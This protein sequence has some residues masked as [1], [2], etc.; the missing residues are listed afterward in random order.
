[1]NISYVYHVINQ[2]HC[3]RFQYNL[4]TMEFVK[5]FH[6]ALACQAQALER[7]L[8]NTFP[9][10]QLVGW[11]L[12]YAVTRIK[13]NQLNYSLCWYSVTRDKKTLQCKTLGNG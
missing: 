8:F 10:S 2:E 4:K 7:K 11:Q 1:M 13:L 6:A 5:Y 12:A 9:L 3:R